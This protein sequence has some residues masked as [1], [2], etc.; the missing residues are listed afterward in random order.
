M[1][2]KPF[3]IFFILMSLILTGSLVTDCQS[4][5]SAQVMPLQ[6][7][8]E[9]PIP[10]QAI[11]AGLQSLSAAECGVCHPDHYL[12]WKQSTHAVA[13]QD[14][15]FQAELR[16]ENIIF[17]IN[18]HTPLQNQQ[19]FIVKGTLNG[20]YSRPVK[21]KN[22]HFDRA[23]QLE[24]ITCATCHVRNGQVIGTQGLGTAPH[25]T[26]KDVEFLS[27]TICLG[28]HNVVDVVNPT[29]VC[30]FETGDE[31]SRN[32]AKQAGKNCVSC[33]MPDT[34]RNLFP[35]LPKRPSHVHKFPAS[36]IPKFF[37]LLPAKL[38]S[39]DIQETT[40]DTIARMADSLVYTLTIKNSFAGHAVPTG[41]PERFITIQMTIT[42]SIGRTIQGRNFRIGEQ[43]KWYPEAQKIHDNNLQPLESRN[44]KLKQVWDRP[45]NYHLAIEITKHRMSEENAK[46]HGLLGHYPLSIS[47]FQKH[48]HILVQ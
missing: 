1:S 45:G 43:W 18:C 6:K 37:G 23:L 24:S 10:H 33:H 22:P 7:A 16:K 3:I 35:G 48:Y 21:E 32:W 28:C 15:Q 39:L 25:A 34:L 42:D 13:W 47:I 19:E 5:K 41:D 12:E 8:W 11:P 38:Q 36:G 26:N 14:L 4:K 2:Y 46:H 17:C 9:S 29:L 27:E 20:D 31:W 44:Y 40:P 30:T